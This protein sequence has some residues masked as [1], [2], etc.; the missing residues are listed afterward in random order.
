MLFTF[1]PFRLFELAYSLYSPLLGAFVYHA[2]RLFI[3]SLR[4]MAVPQPLILG[5]HLDVQ[6]IFACIGADGVRLF[7]CLFGL[8]VLIEWNRCN[9]FR[10][11]L[12]YAAGIATILAA[13]ALR[14]VLMVLI[15]NLI[16]ADGVIEVHLVAG[17]LFFSLAFFVF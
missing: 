1:F 10:T 17:S 13:N 6:I 4:Y 15:G 11:L 3:P 2:S 8:I 7:D 14:I 12:S 9:K 16:S 5:P